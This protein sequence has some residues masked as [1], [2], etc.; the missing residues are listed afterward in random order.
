MI[1]GPVRHFCFIFFVSCFLSVHATAPFAS[2][3]DA[4]AEERSFELQGVGAYNAAEILSY[5]AQVEAQRTGTVTALGIAATVQTIYRE[6][7]YFLASATVL[8]DGRTIAVDEGEIGSISIE[9]VDAATFDLIEG[10]FAPIIGKP[11]VTLAEFERAIML[12]EDIQSI[13]ASAEITY[14]EGRQTAHVRIVAEPLGKAS[15]YVTL[16]HPARAFGEAVTL[17]FSQ[18]FTSLLTPGD[19]F[20]FELSGTESIDDGDSDLFGS[21]TYRLPVG[22]AGSYAE[23]YLGNVV[24][25]RDASG[26]LRQT[27]L[28][29]RTVILA[30]GHLFVRDVD[31]YGYGLLEVRRT[32][33]DTDVD[34]TAT[35]FD[36][37][38][39]V[40]GASWIYGKALPNGGA[41]NT[42]SISHSENGPATPRGST[43]AMTASGTCARAAA[44]SSRWAGSERTRLSAWSSGGSTAPTGCRGSRSSIS[45][46][47][48]TNA[49][50]SLRKRGEIAACRRPSRRGVISFRGR[51]PFGGC[52]PSVSSTSDISTTMIPR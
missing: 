40:L 35:D 4:R 8:A 48:M 16:D 46:V 24:G 14:P 29:G 50:I 28:E 47:S 13:S 38:V 2:E 52:G 26:L 6:D 3:R 20:R 41:T 19:L 33:S 42:R 44:I 39:N 12:T 34:G 21:L 9:G 32:S 23:A 15:G 22:A 11:A 10:Y 18:K 51:R 37:A 36:S 25:D 5:A 31:T 30:L 45:V 7:G 27:D 17:T 43:M 1:G 49:G